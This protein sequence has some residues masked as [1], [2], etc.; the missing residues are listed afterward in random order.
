MAYLESFLYLCNLRPW[1]QELNALTAQLSQAT[2]MESGSE[3][4]GEGESAFFT[5]CMWTTKKND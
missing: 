4:T 2:H 3:G 5:S 1:L